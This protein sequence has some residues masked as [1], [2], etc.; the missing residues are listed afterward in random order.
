MADDEKWG[1]QLFAIRNVGE[2]NSLT[3]DGIGKVL[4]LTK[5][6]D[7][8]LPA[9]DSVQNE[10]ENDLYE[11]RARKSMKN[12]LSELKKLVQGASSLKEV[13]ATVP[14]SKIETTDWI[15]PSDNESLMALHKKGIPV[16]ALLQLNKPGNVALSFEGDDGYL[17]RLEE[18]EAAQAD[19][20]ESKKAALSRELEGQE[21]KLYLTGFVAS[22]YRSAKIEQNESSGPI[23][24]DYVHYE[25]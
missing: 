24:E 12:K 23:N 3:Q 22:L 13:Q 7:R 1:K 14:G 15:A 25:D 2:I 21:M 4:Q 5:I 10:V 16:A 19:D 9:F 11:S 6:E 20:F 18:V 17:I 8:T